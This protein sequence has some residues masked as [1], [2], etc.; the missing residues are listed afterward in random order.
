LKAKACNFLGDNMTH[1]EF[2]DLLEDSPVIAAIK[3]EEGLEK[4]IKS[5]LS[6]IFVLYGNVCTIN[7]IVSRLK[8][9]DKIVIVHLDLVEG[10]SSKDIAVDFIKQYTKA[11]GIISTKLVLIKR[12][13]ELSMITV[14]RFFILDSMALKQIDKQLR[15][16]KPD[17]IELLPGPM[18]KI[19]KKICSISPVPV[20]SGG[21]ISEKE[22]VIALLSSGAASIST[23]DAN[24]WVM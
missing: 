1:H 11:D 4:C 21:L 10:L 14:F 12:A 22:D 5:E 7:S 16:V 19:V 17:V 8:E 18:P 3:D 9:A 20:I 6:I 23:T 13:K 15:I 24:I 2:L